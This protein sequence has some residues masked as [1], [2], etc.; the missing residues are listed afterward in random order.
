MRLCAREG[1]ASP[2][3]PPPYL[4]L[5]VLSLRFLLRGA[6]GPRGEEEGEGMTHQPPQHSEHT[7]HA[8]EAPRSRAAIGTWGARTHA[9]TPSANM[10]TPLQ[11]RTPLSPRGN[12]TTTTRAPLLSSSESEGRQSPQYL[13]THTHSQVTSSGSAGP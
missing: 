7:G 11:R 1:R 2:L 3:S 8:R 4:T 9:H 12:D 13:H 5:R 6:V 10:D